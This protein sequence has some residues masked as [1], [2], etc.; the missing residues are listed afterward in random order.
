MATV[1]D[2]VTA[3]LRLCGMRDETDTTRLAEGLEAFNTM[4]KSWEEI[5]QYA[6]VE[7][8]AYTLTAGTE[9]YTIGSGGDI[10]TDRPTK[11]KSA[12]IRDSANNDHILSVLLTKKEY[13]EIY[14]KDA[15]RR[16]DA[17]YYA[18][19]YSLGKI[20]LDSAP[21]T[22]EDLYLTTFKPFSVYSSLNDTLSFP[23]EYE[24]ALIYNLAVDLAPEYNVQLIPSV[25][26][27]SIL[28]KNA[29]MIRNSEPTRSGK[30]DT[31]L[32]RRGYK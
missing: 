32:I 13:D 17:L 24:K 19:E 29:I 20:Y 26:E 18:P 22:A 21:A 27:Q 28:T 15:S 7:E 11:V 31:A 30:Y 1:N 6:P 8:S 14:D 16:P 3:S 4:I 10:D 9:S 23:L 5:L 12:F 2:I 25:I